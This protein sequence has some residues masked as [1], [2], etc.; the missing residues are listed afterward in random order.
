[1][2]KSIIAYL[3]QITDIEYLPTQT[4]H[5]VEFHGIH[6]FS[7]MGGEY[8]HSCHKGCNN[9][10][11]PC[12]G[13]GCEDAALC[14]FLAPRQMSRFGMPLSWYKNARPQCFTYELRSYE[15]LMPSWM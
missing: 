14:D 6:G 13:R 5:S 15:T 12:E 8:K 7:N 1:M 10:A 9:P 3:D 4:A 11:C 2:G